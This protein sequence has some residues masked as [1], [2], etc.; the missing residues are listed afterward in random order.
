MGI[1]T[2]FFFFFSDEKIIQAVG[3][4]PVLAGHAFLPLFHLR[5]HLHPGLP[6]VD[7]GLQIRLLASRIRLRALDAE[8]RIRLARADAVRQ[9]PQLRRPSESL[10]GRPERHPAPSGHLCRATVPYLSR[11]SAVGYGRETHPASAAQDVQRTEMQRSRDGRWIGTERHGFERNVRV[12]LQG[13][14]DPAEPYGRPVQPIGEPERWRRAQL[15]PALLQPLLLRRRAVVR[16]PLDRPLGRHSRPLVRHHLRHLSHRSASIPVRLFPSAQSRHHVRIFSCPSRYPERPLIFLSACYV[17][18]SIGY[19]VRVAV[20]GRDE[21]ACEGE[22]LRYGAAPSLMANV[23]SS[24]PGGG[25][26]ASFIGVSSSTSSPT[27][28]VTFLLVYF[29]G[30]AAGLW[31]VISDGLFFSL[32]LSV[33]DSS[34]D[35][36]RWEML[37]ARDDMR[38]L[39][40]KHS[41]ADTNPDRIHV[42]ARRLLTL[43]VISCGTVIRRRQDKANR[44]TRRDN[45]Y[46]R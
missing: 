40:D 24:V 5:S 7:S 26:G 35:A 41:R 43:V 38:C 1:P 8:I 36:R 17:G 10:H 28:V 44:F 11:R 16:L 19:L 30:Q 13:T 22:T 37:R 21:V 31:Y 20:G 14:F 32:F 45:H 2:D 34:S 9:V 23:A 46:R 15:P 42:A 6:D 4:D 12:P 39:A 25:S 3:G 33:S 18:L 27:C 29:F